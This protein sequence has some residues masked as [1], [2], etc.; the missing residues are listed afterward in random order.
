MYNYKMKVSIV[1]PCYNIEKYIKPMIDSIKNSFSDKFEIEPIIVNDKSTDNTG[2][3]IAN[4]IDKR[5]IYINNK[6]N[7]GLSRT[8]N[9]GLEQATG[10]YIYFLDGDDKLSENFVEEISKILNWNDDFIRTCENGKIKKIKYNFRYSCQVSHLLIK[11][12][13]M[14][15][16]SLYQINDILFEDNHYMALIEDALIKSNI[17]KVKTIGWTF[18]YT[19]GREDSIT[20]S[21]YSIK[22]LTMSIDKMKELDIS[23][24]I[25]NRYLF[26][27][28]YSFHSASKYE[29]RKIIDKDKKDFLNLL[30]KELRDIKFW[31]LPILYKIRLLLVKLF[32]YSKI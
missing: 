27:L 2:K 21:K 6:S 23:E 22:K 24:K 1:I 31:S 28:L 25:K 8:R 19:T 16:N 26:I 11:R 5:F 13:F 17:K 3:V 9:I 10:D 7:K 20:H 32:K 12:D 30:A 18:V 15:E 29:N 14:I 4:E